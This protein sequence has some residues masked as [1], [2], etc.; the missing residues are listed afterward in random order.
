MLSVGAVAKSVASI[1]VLE[2]LICQNNVGFV[3]V[4]I[5]II[6]AYGIQK[7]V[8]GSEQHAKKTLFL[9]NR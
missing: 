9:S 4:R 8:T 3:R 1:S 6:V 5:K 7:Q 2:A